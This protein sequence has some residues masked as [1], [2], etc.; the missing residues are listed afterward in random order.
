MEKKILNIV[1][2]ATTSEKAIEAYLVKE[3]TKAG[4]LCLKYSNPNATGYPDRVVIEPNGI[5]QWVELKSK[6]RRPSPIQQIRF[7][8]LRSLGHEI[9]IIDSREKVDA[10]IRQL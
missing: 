3:V 7:D 2:Y 5:V 8:E 1:E 4:C 9:F 10:F 6:G